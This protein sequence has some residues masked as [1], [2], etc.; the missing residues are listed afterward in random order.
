MIKYPPKI[1]A[2]LMDKVYR[3]IYVSGPEFITTNE[4]N[5]MV[6]NGLKEKGINKE[7]IKIG[8]LLLSNLAEPEHVLI[9]GSTGMGKSVLMNQVLDQTQKLNY[10]GLCYDFKSDFFSRFFREKSD[11]LFNPLDN[12]SILW[13]FVKDIKSFKDSEIMRMAANISFCHSLIPDIPSQTSNSSNESYFR[14]GARAILESLIT[15]LIDSCHP[16]K[17]NNSGL[18]ELLR[19][20]DV[21]IRD[22]TKEVNPIAANYI[23]TPGSNQTAGVLSVLS[24]FTKSLL[25]MD[26]PG[27]NFSMESFVYDNKPG[28]I[29]ITGYSMMRDMLRPVLSLF[30][31]TISKH[32]MNRPETFNVDDRIMTFLDE[33]QTLQTL[34]SLVEQV[35]LTRSKGCSTWLTCQDLSQME[36]RYGSLK[37]SIINSCKTKIIY[38]LSD[39]KD[40]HYFSDYIGQVKVLTETLQESGIIDGDS[41]LSKWDARN[42]NYS[43][44]MEKIDLVL[45]SNIINQKKFHFIFKSYE[46]PFVRSKILLDPK[47]YPNKVP[48]LQLRDSIKDSEYMKSMAKDQECVNNVKIIIVDVLKGENQQDVKITVDYLKTLIK[49]ISDYSGDRDNYLNQAIDSLISENKI[50]L[51]REEIDGDKIIYYKIKENNNEK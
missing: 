33:V 50:T 45:P 18:L 1:L 10:K 16:K 8:D 11:R 3:E 20:S 39:P 49:H 19:M 41:G 47:A 14:E 9:V 37:H 22:I 44:R 25:C 40:A 42:A 4:Y 30:I 24:R 2:E 7:Q 34:N 6:L 17:H 35:T 31:D 29:F 23:I 26:Y 36:N 21:R 48:A 15:H 43:R 51:E 46:Y 28:F 38:G 13:N 27:E 32:I 5:S 12:R